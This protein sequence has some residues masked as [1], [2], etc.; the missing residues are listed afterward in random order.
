MTKE[1]IKNDLRKILEE[2]YSVE[3][4]NEELSLD[5][6]GL[7]SLDI[8]DLM[9]KLEDTYNIELVDSE[10]EELAD[11]NFGDIVETLYEKLQ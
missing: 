10:V 5:M 2:D 7:D 1:K 3:D 11:K 8:V 9:M 4:V 6:L